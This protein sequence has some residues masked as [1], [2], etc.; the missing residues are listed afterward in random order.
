M[1]C[2]VQAR[3]GSKRLNRKIFKKIK[4][5]SII[6]RVISR[7][8]KS[9]KISK[10]IIATSIDKKDNDIEKFCKKKKISYYR[11]SLNNVALR[12]LQISKKYNLK[13]LIRISCD[14]PFINYKILDEGI[15][16]FKKNEFDIITNV[17]PRTYPKGL[18]YEIFKTSILKN[19]IKFFSNKDKEH[20]T[21][22]FY[23]NFK[24]YK[25]YNF[26]SLKRFKNI[27]L[28]VDTKK[29]LVFLRKNYNKILKLNFYEKN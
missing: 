29:D 12:F 22:F 14:S 16:L 23:K 21:T 8:E 7:L 2:V 28:C 11:G 3:C 25:I 18:S 17:F 9:K 4:N 10:I 15:S 20:V 26:Y 6:E 5:K 24:N 19:N 1:Y 13:S 27:N